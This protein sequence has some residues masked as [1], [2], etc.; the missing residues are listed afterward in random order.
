LEHICWL[1]A[2][3][4]LLLAGGA[5]RSVQTF[6]NDKF[7]NFSTQKSIRVPP[8]DFLK[9]HILIH[10]SWT[11]SDLQNFKRSAHQN[12]LNRRFYYWWCTKIMILSLNKHIT[13]VFQYV[14]QYEVGRV[15][16]KKCD[17][18]KEQVLISKYAS[19]QFGTRPKALCGMVLF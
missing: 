14:F 12:T 19:F 6:I 5:V 13:K 11:V 7:K 3:I 8:L 1:F 4:D 16:E 17:F 15:P 18:M 9:T 10:I 2:L